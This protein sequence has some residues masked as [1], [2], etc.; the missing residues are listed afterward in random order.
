M[1]NIKRN[2]YMFKKGDIVQIISTIG[3]KKVYSTPKQ[4]SSFDG[5]FYHLV[6]EYRVYAG[7]YLR[8]YNDITL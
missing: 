7:V 4:I 6:G 5:Y 3:G 8:L 1:E 2:G